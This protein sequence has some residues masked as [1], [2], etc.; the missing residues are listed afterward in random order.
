L[1]RSI[2]D[3]AIDPR[4]AGVAEGADRVGDAHRGAGES[5]TLGLWLD[6]LGRVRKARWTATP[7]DSDALAAYAEVACTLLESGV[8]PTSVDAAA[9]RRTLDL[10]PAHDGD[11][12]LV[13][14]AILSALGATF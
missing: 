14:E 9:L 2:S 1:K 6:D 8:A 4:H 11:A 10:A 3:R 12:D 13:A 7:T 5:V